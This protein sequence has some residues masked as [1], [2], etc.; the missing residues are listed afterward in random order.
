MTKSFLIIMKRNMANIVTMMRI[1]LS[2]PLLMLEPLSL[3]FY[4]I[5]G[6]CGL[7]DMADGFVARRTNAVSR[8]GERLDSIADIV[9]VA[10]CL[11]KLLPLIDLARWLYV[12]VA[13][14]A[15]IKVVNV[16]IGY[17]RAHSF[18]PV[19]SMMN[20]L[21]GFILFLFPYFI[22]TVEVT[23]AASIVCLF[24]SVAAI[25]E[26]FVMIKTNSLD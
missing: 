9:F 5:Y 7:S 13:A 4:I 12:W 11:C 19:H 3:T 8:F 21:T 1:V 24:A 6:L 22:G 10:A 16:F 26:C 17:V 20:K 14:I 2:F 25:Q 23:L 15:V 18:V